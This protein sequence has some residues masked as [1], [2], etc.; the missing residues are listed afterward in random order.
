MAGCFY[1][2]FGGQ[3]TGMFYYIFGGCYY[4]AF[5]S[6][7]IAFSPQLNENVKVKVKYG[8]VL[9]TGLA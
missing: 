8:F 4:R 9:H 3:I 7:L 1:Y 6:S 2:I 5:H